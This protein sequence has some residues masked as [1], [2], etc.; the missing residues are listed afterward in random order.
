MPDAILTAGQRRLRDEARRFAREEVSRQLLL[1][2]DADKVRYPRE[3]AQKL[4][5][6][7]LLGLRFPEEFGGRGLDW[8]HEVLALEEIG[9]LGASLA[10]L[11]S[12]PSI[13]GEAIHVFCSRE[14]KEKYLKPVLTGK[15]T[16]AEALTEPRG[17]SDFFGATATAKREGDHY[18]LNGQKR[19]IVGAE[20][21]DLFMVYARTNLDATSHKAISAF[22]VERGEGVE[23]K[24]IYGLMG[25]RGG[26]TGRVYFREVRVPVENL[27]GEEHGAYEV[28]HQMMIPE[29]MTS[30]AGALGLARAALE[31]SAR[32][33]DRRKAFGQ[34]I[35]EFEGVSF[36]VAES[37]TRLDAA[38]ALV[39]ETARLI[40]TTGNSSHVRRMVSE[41]KKFATETAWSVVNDAMQ[42][43]GGIGYT[44]VYPIERLLRDA[45]LMMIWTGTNEIMNLVIQHEYFKELL[46]EPPS[47]RDVEADAQNADAE[48]EKVYE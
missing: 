2:M 5:A 27:I 9:V 15:M 30:A 34:K 18:I 44:N 36:K 26:G 39:H 13:V 40:D 47:T 24:H 43:M 35:R 16:V 6:H 20:G 28:F 41:S 32:Y 11:F 45:R 3:Y 23:V 17:G 4:A 25:T 38:R 10:C 7:R 19:F 22:L 37:L 12:L 48:G 8:A 31:I 33:A 29:R 1:D 46:A 14:Q 21:A 42:I